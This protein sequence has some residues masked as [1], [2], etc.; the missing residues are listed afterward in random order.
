MSCNNS[1]NIH[2]SIWLAILAQMLKLPPLFAAWRF[3][4]FQNKS[5]N[6]K[7]L[8]ILS[9]SLFLPLT[10]LYGKNELLW[11]SMWPSGVFSWERT[12]PRSFM[13]ITWPWAPVGR[14]SHGLITLRLKKMWAFKLLDLCESLI[15]YI[16]LS[17]C[18]WVHI[19][20]AINRPNIILM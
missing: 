12:S 19:T 5:H 3:W 14:F 10:C 18:Q 20:L 13:Q 4:T 9:Q 15:V 7:A 16:L 8:V 1:L 17:T 11:V 2:V 6:M